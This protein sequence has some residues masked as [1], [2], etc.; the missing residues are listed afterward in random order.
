MNKWGRF[1]TRT[2]ENYN[3]AKSGL[4]KVK[5]KFDGFI[6][7]FPDITPSEIMFIKDKW[8]KLPKSI[9][10]GVKIMALNFDETFKTLLVEYDADSYIVP[11][12]HK[13]EYEVGSVIEGS[14]INRLNGK[15]YNKGDVYR[16]IPNEIHYLTSKDGCLVHSL[17]TQ[18]SDEEIKPLST[19]LKKTLKIA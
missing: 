18:H 10:S 8:E 4:R 9:G 17:L 6:I 3:K 2:D 5:E 11:H 7:D 15:I 16:I 12:K 1:L 13:L 19:K 14:V